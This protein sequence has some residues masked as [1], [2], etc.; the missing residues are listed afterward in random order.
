MK[1][2]GFKRVFSREPLLPPHVCSL[3]PLSRP[4]PHPH[5]HRLATSLPPL[6]PS[7][8]PPTLHTQNHFSGVS[9]IAV[10][11]GWDHTCAIVTGGSFKCW[12]RNNGGQ[13]GIGN[14]V[15][16]YNPVNV[17]LPGTLGARI[18]CHVLRWLG[19]EI[20]SYQF[21]VMLNCVYL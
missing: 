14:T 12:G 5:H 4:S 1:E 11:L 3:S 2:K 8:P 16:Q 17:T 13:L 9:A 19:V 20:Y 10:S 18:V 21:S 7:A 15:D 6:Y